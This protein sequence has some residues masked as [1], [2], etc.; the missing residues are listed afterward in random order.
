MDRWPLCASRGTLTL[1]YL[2]LLVG[3]LARAV[4]FCS[5]CRA[6]IRNIQGVEVFVAVVGRRPEIEFWEKLLLM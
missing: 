2:N 6:D 4:V 1:L 3:L 5:V